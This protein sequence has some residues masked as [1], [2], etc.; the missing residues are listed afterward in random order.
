MTN[1][2]RRLSP[3][4]RVGFVVETNLGHRTHL[5][6][7]IS[8]V[9]CHSDIEPVWSPIPF[10]TSLLARTLPVYRSNWTVRAGVRSRTAIARMHRQARLDALYFHTQV[11]ATFCQ[12]WMARI[13]SVVSVDATP[14]QFDAFGAAYDHLR[15]SPWLERWKLSIN[16][17]CFNRAAHVVAWSEWVRS[18]ICL[19]YGI[20]GAKVS[21]VPPGID[22]DFWRMAGKRALIEPLRILF[23]GA[24]FDRKGGALLIDAFK[25][26]AISDAELHVVTRSRVEPAENVRVYSHLSPNDPG[27]RRLYHYCNVLA[28][29]TYGDFSPL[30]LLEA[31]AAGLAIVAT[32]VG[33]ITEVVRNGV[34]GRLVEV[35][36]AAALTSALLELHSNPRLRYEFATE[37]YALVCK[38]NNIAVTT[39]RILDLIRLASTGKDVT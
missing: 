4:L 33:A 1:P 12:D 13:P 38:R 30:V 32:N 6:N 3:T 31:A 17:A 10:E 14:V 18:S 37:A 15:S 16:R 35:G 2:H 36:S 8:R 23:V 5:A 27:L 22:L 28:L 34:T 9:R 39:A 7:L 29:P 20:D 26:L 25:K 21:V 24:D 19:D 11:P